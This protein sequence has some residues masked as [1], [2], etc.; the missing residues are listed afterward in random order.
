MV[1]FMKNQIDKIKKI[2]D[3]RK[4][5][6]RHLCYIS[7]VGYLSNESLRHKNLIILT[8]E[9]MKEEMIYCLDKK[10]EEIKSL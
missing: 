4:I 2:L 5:K 6:G 1:M 8:L 7:T 9:S 3:L 10:I